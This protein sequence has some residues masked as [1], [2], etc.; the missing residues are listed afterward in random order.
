MS[1]TCE[2][3]RSYELNLTPPDWIWKIVLIGDSGVGKSSLSS[4]YSKDAFYRNQPSTVGILYEEKN[5]SLLG[6]IVKLQ[7]W[8]TAGQERFRSLV[9]SYYRGAH[10][11][12]LVYDVT[13]RETFD[14]CY[15]WLD[16]LTDQAD[17]GIIVVLVGNKVDLIESNFGKKSDANANANANAE[18]KKREVSIEEA[19]TFAKNNHL[20]YIETSAKI[21]TN[22]STLFVTIATELIKSHRTATEETTDVVDTL[23]YNTLENYRLE[24]KS[25][26]RG[27]IS[28]SSSQFHD[29]EGREFNEDSVVLL[30]SHT[31]SNRYEHENLRNKN[32]SSS[33]TVVI[34][35]M[36]SK[37]S[38]DQCDGCF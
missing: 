32:K 17:S 20:L 16:D 21:G 36:E 37:S 3:R 6:Q 5:I 8:D 7:L 27:S 10:A 18:S 33:P 24:K 25:K 26:S 1:E 9:K 4:R 38:E 14:N 13:S 2:R 28:S 29:D 34:E 31:L 22:V 15:M 11:V 19:L 30:N 23:Q 35:N 12:L